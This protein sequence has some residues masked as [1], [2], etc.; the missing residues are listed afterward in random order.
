[1]KFMTNLTKQ[2]LCR[3]KTLKKGKKRIRR[4]AKEKILRGNG[5][6]LLELTSSIKI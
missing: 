2:N 5:Q 3:P 4:N 1:M 6:K